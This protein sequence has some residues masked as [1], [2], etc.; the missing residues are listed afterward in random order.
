MN[1]RKKHFI[2]NAMS[3]FAE[4]GYHTTSVQDIVEAS[5][6]SKGSFYHYFKSKEELVI[7][8]FHY[9][10]EEMDR[11]IKEVDQNEEL[12]PKK[13]FEL[14]LL[15]QFEEFLNHKDFIRVLMQEQMLNISD[16]L[17]QFLIKIRRESIQWYMNQ[18]K[19]MY[20]H[21]S[22]SQL[23]DATI[24]LGGMTKEYIML[25]IIEG[26]KIP[27]KKVPGLLLDHMDKLVESIEHHGALM[28][29]EEL[30]EL[31][32]T[33][34]PLHER[35]QNELRQV[36]QMVESEEEPRLFEISRTIEEQLRNEPVQWMVVAGLI[37]LLE[38][39]IQDEEERKRLMELR[40]LLTT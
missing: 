28:E 2:K 5:E 18:L 40:Q 6:M 12:S 22:L 10:Y 16:E 8:I 27:Y 13:R 7:S 14:Q 34:L 9:Y 17:D 31:I 20:P 36:M 39:A 38:E 35:V 29:E 24:M 26:V 11:K 1:E 23:W 21:L 32:Q 30:R 15:M 33:N 25:I 19:L 3:L 37:A 4:K